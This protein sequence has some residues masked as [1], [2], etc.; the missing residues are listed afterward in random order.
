MDSQ[1]SQD[2]EGSAGEQDDLF[3]S[4]PDS[5]S[6]SGHQGDEGEQ[7]PPAAYNEQ[8]GGLFGDDGEDDDFA[9]DQPDD[10]PTTSR[11]NRKVGPA[12]AYSTNVVQGPEP[13]TIKTI[14][15]NNMININKQPF[16]PLRHTPGPEVLTDR[17]GNSR[18]N[19]H[20]LNTVRWRWANDPATGER[21]MQSNARFVHWADGTTTLHIGE[22]VLS[23]AEVQDAAARRYLYVRVSNLMQVWRCRMRV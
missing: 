12:V 14:K 3:G 4:E 15:L 11:A 23:V 7:S 9:Q 2:K 20:H 13:D 22:E 1:L 17:F 21:I 19:L 5:P 8:Y 16:D 10:A 6:S 18:I